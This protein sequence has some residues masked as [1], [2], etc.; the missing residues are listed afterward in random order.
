M[1]TGQDYKNTFRFTL[2]TKGWLNIVYNGK[3]LVLQPD[4]LCICAPGIEVTTDNAA[5]DYEDVCLTVDETVGNAS[6]A[7]NGIL[8]IAYMPIL[9]KNEPFIRLS[10][11]DAQQLL[12]TISKIKHYQDTDESYTEPI[13]N[14]L[15]TAF[16][17]E[18]KRAQGRTGQKSQH[19]AR[20]EKIFMDF[21][22][23]MTQHFSEHHDIAFY[24]SKLN[25]TTIYLSRVVRLIAER[26]VVDYINQ[27]LADK[28]TFLLRHSQLSITQI[29]EQLHFADT[30]SFSKFFTR[31]KG[32][33]PRAFREA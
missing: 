24:A 21:I 18:V 4:D 27:M 11:S 7:T 17:L 29:A 31:Q 6:A 30:P 19:P 16:L 13:L 8:D 25:I 2:V 15:Y 26:T 28:A 3:K 23:L 20:M 12:A 14:T 9:Q 5:D 1:N 33:S 10:G 22:Q 32:M